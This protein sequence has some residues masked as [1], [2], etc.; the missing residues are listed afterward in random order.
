[1]STAP[2]VNH[3]IDDIYALPDGE[4]AEL[5]DGQMYLMAPPNTRH[6]RMAGE[7]FGV[8]REYIRKNKGQCEVFVA[9]F[10]VFLNA[11]HKTY[12][13]PDVCVICDRDKITEQGC[14]GAPDWIIEVVS[15]SSYHRDYFVK[16]FKYKAAGVREYWIVDPDKKRVMVYD[17]ANESGNEYTFSDWVHS[18]T[19]EGLEIDLAE[20]GR[21]L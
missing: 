11:N 4:R 18:V 17:F 12:V 19:L 6:Q 8:I 3:T 10:A 9:P 13:E 15:P 21:G 16:L 20:I 14:D 2:K 5:I 1:M 7:L